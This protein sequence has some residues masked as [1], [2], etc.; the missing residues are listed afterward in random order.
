MGHSPPDNAFENRYQSWTLRAAVL[1]V[2]V[3]LAVGAYLFYRPVYHLTAWITLPVD[4]QQVWTESMALAERDPQIRVD[5]EPSLGF[6]A[7][8]V[9]TSDC[10][11]GRALL[12]GLAEQVLAAARATL[13]AQAASQPARSAEYT[14]LAQTLAA[15]SAGVD[16]LNSSLLLSDE[17][18]RK[19]R[20]AWD[21][22]QSD[23]K[24]IANALAETKKRLSDKA[25]EPGAAGADEQRV[26]EMERNDQELAADLEEQGKLR[27]A[28]ADTLLQIML[29]S[30]AQLQKYTQSITESTQILAQE[31]GS[32]YSDQTKTFLLAMQTALAEGS[33]AAAP[34]IPSLDENIAALT[35]KG[36]ALDPTDLLSKLGPAVRQFLDRSSV[37]QQHVDQ[38]LESIKSSA[39]YLPARLAVL[40]NKLARQMRVTQEARSAAVGATQ[41]LYLAQ[42]VS[43][44]QQV[45]QVSQLTSRIDNRRAEIRNRLRQEAQTAWE[46]QHKA[47]MEQAASEHT[48]LQREWNER[49]QKLL[50]MAEKAMQELTVDTASEEMQKLARLIDWHRRNRE[51][52]AHLLTMDEARE[53][54]LNERPGPAAI[55]Y[56]PPNMADAMRMSGNRWLWVVLG[57]AAPL[58]LYTI[59]GLLMTAR[60]C[61]KRQ[62]T[63]HELVFSDLE[64][65]PGEQQG[66]PIMDLHADDTDNAQGNE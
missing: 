7:M 52:L 37:A 17:Q 25:P 8:S 20:E 21:Q 50:D 62:P 36:T 3:V 11:R 22:L 40:Y 13:A 48:R 56:I 4:Q 23:Q 46:A 33:A 2:S 54:A 39:D 27:Q 66:P 45:N 42:N 10:S 38:A 16:L 26:A 41:A 44:A 58:A 63:F 30:Q 55:R 60:Q 65:L 49:Q 18:H 12:D 34:L 61:F 29:T 51:D 24:R 53:K 43:L 1:A 15:D 47:A 32:D 35:E 57:V 14:A 31:M 28:L 59:G 5:A 9:T 19:W 6:L 64:T